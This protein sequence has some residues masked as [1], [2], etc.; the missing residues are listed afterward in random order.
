MNSTTHV[1]IVPAVT[2]TQLSDIGLLSVNLSPDRKRSDSPS[3]YM[4]TNEPVVQTNV[5]PNG[6]HPTTP[7]VNM[8]RI[9]SDHRHPDRSLIILVGTPS[10]QTLI[11]A[12]ALWIVSK[13]DF[14]AS[15]V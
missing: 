1:V 8:S 15:S 11:S 3:A 14:I 9:L 13:F 2:G 12:P 10:V 4:T 7:A 5:P 6:R